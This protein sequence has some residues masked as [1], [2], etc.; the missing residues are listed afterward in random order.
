MS[1]EVDSELSVSISVDAAS[2]LNLEEEKETTATDQVQMV[3]LKQ[4]VMS[5]FRAV[6]KESPEKELEQLEVSPTTPSRSKTS[7]NIRGAFEGFKI[8]KN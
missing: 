5:H 8:V 6:F 1:I 7:S 4:A 3:N 2:I